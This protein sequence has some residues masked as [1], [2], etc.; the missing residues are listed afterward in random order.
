MNIFNAIINIISKII[1]LRF[2][3]IDLVNMNIFHIDTSVLS[4]LARDKNL[5]NK[6][7]KYLKSNNAAILLTDVLMFEILK[8]SDKKQVRRTLNMLKTVSAKCFL[9]MDLVDIH[10]VELVD[11][12]ILGRI[13]TS[14]EFKNHFIGNLKGP[15]WDL[16]VKK[17]Q[18]Y[19]TKMESE[20]GEWTSGWVF[21][22]MIEKTKKERKRKPLKVKDILNATGSNG[23][24]LELSKYHKLIDN[25]IDI[26]EYQKHEKAILN[27]IESISFNGFQEEIKRWMK[28]S[29]LPYDV[30]IELNDNELNER[31]YYAEQLRHATKYL[32]RNIDPNDFYNKMV[33]AYGQTF[34][35]GKKI[36]RCLIEKRQS[37]D[38][39]VRRSDPYDILFMLLAPYVDLITCDNNTHNETN[40]VFKSES[41]KVNAKIEK[42]SDF[43]NKLKQIK[44]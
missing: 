10:W 5:N 4:T 24:R 25:K 11:Y 40:Q 27:S 7:I 20:L 6:F 35:I 26:N 43:I 17:M 41:I 1:K 29:M 9:R 8:N 13:K 19:T 14:D 15:N 21:G 33:P 23:K 12:F 37:N 44:N 31:V 42:N 30:A 34:G 39:K 18:S 32:P 16:Y 2:N 3:N 28:L 38:S 36:E 22:K